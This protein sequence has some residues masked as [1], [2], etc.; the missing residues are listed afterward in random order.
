MAAKAF[1]WKSLLP[2]L[3][4]LA[5]YGGSKLFFHLAGAEDHLFLSRPTA[6]I[7]SLFTAQPFETLE[8]S[9]FFF[10][11]LNAVIDASCSGHN[12]FL[13][14]FLLLS[15]TS[16]AYRPGWRKLV[17]IITKSFLLAF[18]LTIIGNSSRILI[19][20]GFQS[21]LVQLLSLSDPIIHEALGVL[22][23]FST[24]VGAYLLLNLYLKKQNAKFA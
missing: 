20:L 3:F 14:S 5:I 18:G 21:K 9:S 12:F 2:H 4:L 22:V 13:L 17:G 11:G 16:L 19:I 15:W 23:Y 8:E 10:P 7:I 1:H 24:L 6:G